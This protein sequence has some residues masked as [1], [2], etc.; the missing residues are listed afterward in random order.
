MKATSFDGVG[1]GQLNDQICYAPNEPGWLVSIGKDPQIIFHGT[2]V[3]EGRDYRLR[4][5][6]YSDVEGMAQLFVRH[7][8]GSIGFSAENS[9][10]RPVHPGLNSLE[11]DLPSTET[12]TQ[13]RFDPLNLPGRFRILDMCLHA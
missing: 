12:R 5:G 10:R 6:M 9:F 4:I 3:K 8:N 11:F 1:I 2:T 7:I 13:L